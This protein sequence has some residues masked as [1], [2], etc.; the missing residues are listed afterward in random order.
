MD[1][2]Q[3]RSEPDCVF[4]RTGVVRTHDEKSLLENFVENGRF[5]RILQE[6]ALNLRGLEGWESS[7]GCLASRQVNG[8]GRGRRGH[9]HGSFRVRNAVCQTNNFAFWLR[10]LHF[11]QRELRSARCGRRGE[12]WHEDRGRLELRWVGFLNACDECARST[13]PIWQ[14]PEY[15]QKRRSCEENAV[16]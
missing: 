6:L 9:G 11:P 15:L 14:D 1:S 12:Q 3:E 16:M 7:S 4:E 5:H 8:V 10:R 2:R 13:L